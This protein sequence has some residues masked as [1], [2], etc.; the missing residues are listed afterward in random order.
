M[1]KCPVERNYDDKGSRE[2]ERDK[3][4]NKPLEALGIFFLEKRLQGY[5]FTFS[6]PS[7]GD[8][9]AL[10]GLKM[11][12]WMVEGRAGPVLQRKN[13]RAEGLGGLLRGSQVG[14]FIQ[15][16]TGMRGLDGSLSIV[17]I[18][19]RHYQCLRPVAC[20]RPLSSHP[21]PGEQSLRDLY[22]L[23]LLMNTK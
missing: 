3:N 6:P 15:V 19:G 8:W 5:M 22:I 17:C 21:D 9:V 20:S 18:R 1:G 2:R 11:A 23:L 10:H 7:L 4:D 14:Q 13:A 12:E 16:M